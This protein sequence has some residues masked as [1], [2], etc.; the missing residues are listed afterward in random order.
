[1]CSL[2]TGSAVVAT[3]WAATGS[4]F[5]LSASS[6]MQA[7][8]PAAGIIR[9]FRRSERQPPLLCTAR[10]LGIAL[11]GRRAVPLDNEAS[12]WPPSSPSTSS[13]D[14]EPLKFDQALIAQLEE[15]KDKLAAAAELSGQQVPRALDSETLSLRRRISD[16]HRSEKKSALSMLLQNH[17]LE[18]FREMKVPLLR[19]FVTLAEQSTVVDVTDDFGPT[20]LKRLATTLYSEDALDL[21]KDHIL[22]IIGKWDHLVRDYKLQIALFQVGQV[23]WLSSLFGYSLRRADMRFRLERV[24]AT[25]HD[26][27]SIA[28]PKTLRDYVSGFGISEA[29]LVASD[30]SSEAQMAIESQVF[31]LF[32]DLHSLRDRI[33]GALDSLLGFVPIDEASAA[34][35]EAILHGE[36]ESTTI[37]VAGLRRVALEGV[38]YGF[39]LG[40]AETEVDSSFE[41]TPASAAQGIDL[42]LPG[43][44]PSGRD[45]LFGDLSTGEGWSFSYFR[46]HDS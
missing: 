10:N 41:L 23:Y 31:S 4:S 26:A 36:V 38:A 42:N 33:L 19:P 13:S 28:I 18:G 21:V 44:S 8:A 25:G 43:D 1:M 29:L 22:N 46:T 24:V 15:L 9:A 34:L 7:P 17:V 39:L 6:H 27:T 12:Q 2:T 11:R 5:A 35:R 45:N 20:H 32:G 37:T 14:K 16:V 40:N 3:S 30:M